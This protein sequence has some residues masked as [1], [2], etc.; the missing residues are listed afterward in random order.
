M[1][2]K[3]IKT[4]LT[5]INNNLVNA[6]NIYTDFKF[7]NTSNIEE[8]KI[9]KNTLE[10]PKYFFENP[11]STIKEF[12]KFDYSEAN[13]DGFTVQGITT[14][15][16]KYC[17]S[18]Y[19]KD[20]ENSRIYIYNDLGIYEGV[21][22]LDNSSHVGN[23]TYDNVNNILLV[24]GDNGNINAYNCNLIGESI[25][26]LNNEST[27]TLDINNL[28]KNI[29]INN[30][31]NIMKNTDTGQAATAYYNDGYLYAATFNRN[32]EG[33]LVKY[34]INY[35]KETNSIEYEEI[36]TN[37][38]NCFASVPKYTQGIAITE[39][40]NK[41]YLVVSQSVG[42]NTK[43]NIINDI[44]DA[45]NFAPQS[46]ILLYE[47]DE[48]GNTNYLGKFYDKPGL[49][50]VV[51]NENNNVILVDEYSYQETTVYSMDEI[52]NKAT[53]NNNIFQEAFADILK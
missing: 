28:N 3:K 32:S 2:I 21:I 52:I 13:N 14:I 4:D 12:I 18:A 44:Q 41:Q 6:N 11:N 29:K 15:G 38:R 16:N 48:S 53:P 17:I 30:N 34:K 42:I 50:G 31:Q 24:T 46:N 22:I 35:N 45:L 26:N 47:I 10:M 27:Y 7:T 23:L 36:I 33:D 9:E 20:G 8:I 25:N 5:P 37:D 40:N 39:Y 49:E 19:N 1:N 51:I 43:N